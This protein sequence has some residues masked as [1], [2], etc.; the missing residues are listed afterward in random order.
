[1]GHAMGVGVVG[2]QLRGSCR[3]CGWSSSWVWWVGYAMGLVWFLADLGLLVLCCGFVFVLWVWVWVMPW[4]CWVCVCVCI[5][6]CGGGGGGA[7]VS[8]W[9]HRLTE[10]KIINKRIVYCS[11]FIILLCYLYYFIVLKYKIKPLMLGKIN[12][13]VFCSAK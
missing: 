12:K 11:R 3:G 7:T 8:A 4:G 10:K 2:Y 1:M 6:I 9:R 13:V 5:C